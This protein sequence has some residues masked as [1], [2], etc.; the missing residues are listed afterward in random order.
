LPLSWV[1]AFEHS[2]RRHYRRVS[3]LHRFFFSIY[4]YLRCLYRSVVAVTGLAGHAFGSWRN[5]ESR[6]MWLQD[7][8]PRDVKNVRIM[9]YG[10]NSRL[11][12]Y[13]DTNTMLDYR[14]NLIQQL[15]NA[16]SSREVGR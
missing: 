5:R 7:F 4:A 8:L 14:R 11:D 2:Q 9:I 16:R 3:V 15:E 13:S 12:D 1:D 6:Q 10:Y